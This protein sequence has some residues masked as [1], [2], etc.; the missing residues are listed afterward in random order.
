MMKVPLMIVVGDKEAENGT[1]SVRLSNGK[2][3]NSVPIDKLT[4]WIVKQIQ[5]RVLEVQPNLEV[6]H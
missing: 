4:T 3:I 1:V 6:S 2:Q 5:D